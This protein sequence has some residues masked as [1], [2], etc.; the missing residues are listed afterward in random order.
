M[1]GLIDAL[2][3]RILLA[4]HPVGSVYQSTASTNPATL[5]GGTWEQITG[6]FLLSMGAVEKNK[7][8]YWGS[9]TAGSLKPGYAGETGGEV[10][11]T[12][13][14]AQL[15][16]LQGWISSH[17][18]GD[19]SKASQWYGSGGVFSASDSFPG[20]VPAPNAEGNGATSIRNIVFSAGGGQPHNNIPPYYAV[21]TWRRT[22]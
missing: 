8:D 14:E 21:Y 5:F 22:A 18:A 17:G 13:T 3:K 6:R 16:T 20:Y 7:T 4:A 10:E 19:N 11:H 2:Y 12:L 15:P 9:I 1:T